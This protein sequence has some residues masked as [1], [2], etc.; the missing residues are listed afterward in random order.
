MLGLVLG[1]GL[2]GGFLTIPGLLLTFAL[3]GVPSI[4]MGWRTIREAPIYINRE[5]I[6]AFRNYVVEKA[7]YMPSFVLHTNFSV[8]T[9]LRRFYLAF[10]LFWIGAGLYFPPQMPVLLSGEGYSRGVIYLALIA[11][12][13]VSA[14]NYTRVG[15][16][17]GKDKEGVLRR[18]L[19]LRAGALVAIV[20]GTMVSS[21]LL[22]LAFL[23]YVLAG[24][25]WT[26]IS[27]SSTAIVSE[28]AGG[29]RE[30]GSAMGTYNLVSSAGYVTGS[31][32][33]GLLVS[34]AGF[35]AAFGLGLAL[36]GGGAWPC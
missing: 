23:S 24:Y 10:L 32:L 1:F 17:M 2:S 19:M 7:R 20:A 31:A 26:F 35:G 8:P 21:A 33:S 11:N 3:T 15:L 29:E 28:R 12:S 16:G 30:K 22:P 27:V 36:L 4:I 5:A 25:S 6:R 14:L 13:A 9:S 34:S 18:G